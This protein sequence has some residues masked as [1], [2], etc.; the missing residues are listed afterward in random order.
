MLCLGFMK[1]Q[2]KRSFLVQVEAEVA[3]LEKLKASKMK[4]LV[5]KKKIE[6]DEI[7]RRTH[8]VAET[9]SYAETII[10]AMENGTHI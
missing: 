8:L 3:R 6:L 7:C 2:V 10:K 4:E 1:Y 5:L 9:D